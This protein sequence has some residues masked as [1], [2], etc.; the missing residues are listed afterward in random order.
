[1]IRLSGAGARRFN[2]LL[3]SL[4]LN[5]SANPLEVYE[6]I[7]PVVPLPDISPIAVGETTETGTVN[8]AHVQLF[9]PANSNVNL[10][11]ILG[12]CTVDVADIL[13][14][15]YHDTALTTLT[16]DPEWADRTRQG[17][18]RGEIRKQDVAG[19]GSDHEI[20]DV[21]AATIVRSAIAPVVV[22]GP[23]QGFL[24]RCATTALKIRGCFVWRERL[25]LRV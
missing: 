17:G 23:G 7:M 18:P 10:E 15:V 20:V 4:S 16:S 12:Q 22:L 2:R 1:M 14:W 6:G 21:L 24:V 19:A 13:R 11:I 3:N 9:N 8:V 25:I 5:E